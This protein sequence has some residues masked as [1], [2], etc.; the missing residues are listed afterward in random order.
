MSS[1]LEKLVLQGKAENKTLSCF[2]GQFYALEIPFQHTIV[3]TQID[4][5][6]FINFYYV[7]NRTPLNDLLDRIQYQLRISDD[8]STNFIHFNNSSCLFNMIGSSGQGP[9]SYDMTTDITRW[10]NHMIFLNGPMIVIPTFLPIQTEL[11]MAITPCP[12]NNIGATRNTL[13]NTSKEEIMPN[14]IKDL[15]QVVYMNNVLNTGVN[16]HPG[17]YPINNPV[18][19]TYQQNKSDGYYYGADFQSSIMYGVDTFPVGLKMFSQPLFTIHYTLLKENHLI[20][21]ID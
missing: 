12:L 19:S 10:L 15:D 3:I 11:R 21:L 17:V 9:A 13:T 18:P 1:L 6:P 7:E 4:W 5:T 2:G 8:R 20:G 16:Y 14:G